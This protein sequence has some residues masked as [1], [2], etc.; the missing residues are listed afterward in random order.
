MN[1]F[2][3]IIFPKGLRPFESPQKEDCA[4]LLNPPKAEAKL[5]RA[6]RL[7]GARQAGRD[8]PVRF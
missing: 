6:Q 1:G 4:L 3:V 2:F 8:E 7:V 5:P